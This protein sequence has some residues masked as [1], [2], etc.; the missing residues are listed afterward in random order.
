[1]SVKEIKNLLDADSFAY[2]SLEGLKKRQELN[3]IDFVLRVLPANIQCPSRVVL[4][5]M[6]L[7]RLVNVNN[8]FMKKLAILISD[9][10]TGTNLQ[11]IINSVKQ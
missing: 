8:E 10:G 3:Q 5:K 11:A 1:M 6:F 2:L 4:G 7:K 9:A